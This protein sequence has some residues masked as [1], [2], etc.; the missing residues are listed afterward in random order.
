MEVDDRFLLP[1]FQ[2]KVPRHLT[3]VLRDF[4]VSFLPIVK[5]AATNTQ[6]SNEPFGRYLRP[7][8]PVVDIV[9][10]RI[11]RVVGNPASF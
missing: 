1:V 3:I 7:L 10:D 9:D 6:P 11:A 5:L 8:G 2:P 4:A